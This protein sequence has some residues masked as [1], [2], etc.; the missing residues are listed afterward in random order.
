MNQAILINDDFEYIKQDSCWRF[1]GM[2]NAERVTIYI[3]HQNQTLT[4][5]LK[6]DL[7]EMVE[8]FLEE[9]EPDDKN[10]IWL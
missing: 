1:T 2:L 9:D 3:K 5:S 4:D 6:F 7:E 10:E 8:E